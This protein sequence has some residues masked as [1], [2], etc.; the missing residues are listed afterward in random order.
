MKTRPERDPLQMTQC[1]YS[2]PCEYGRS[3]VGET[4][5]PLTV[6]LREHGHNLQQHFLEKSK[7]PQHAYEEGHR[8]GWN[9]ARVWEIE[10]NSRYRK[11]KESAYMACLT[12]PISQPSLDISPIWI[13][14]SAMRFLT[15]REDLYDMTDSPHLSRVFRFYSTDGTSGRYYMSSMPNGHCL[16]LFGIYNIFS[17]TIKKKFSQIFP[18]L[19]SDALALGFV[20]YVCS[21][22]FLPPFPSQFHTCAFFI[23]IDIVYFLVISRQISLVSSD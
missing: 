11:Y 13:P 7:L 20:G 6:R 19:C 3:Y 8:V 9:D 12:N 23:T 21:K 4:S 2:I 16:G 17:S 1:I 5:R 10:S 14:S 18:F 15:R 22:K